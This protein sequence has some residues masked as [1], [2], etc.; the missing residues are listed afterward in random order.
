MFSLLVSLFTY[1]R[2]RKRLTVEFDNTCLIFNSMKNIY[3]N[4]NLFA[5]PAPFG[6]EIGISLVNPG[7]CNISIFDLMVINQRT[8]RRQSFLLKSLIPDVYKN[9]QLKIYLSEKERS[10]P[11]IPE[12][13]SALIRSGE[14]VRIDLV[15]LTETD[16]NN[17]DALLITFKSTDT[18]WINRSIYN[19]KS[20]KHIYHAYEK[21]YS[22]SDAEVITFEKD[23]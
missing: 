19:K 7:H 17:T 11:E 15:I 20:K 5:L 8:G 4:D 14:Y 1:W 6:V 9:C 21:T 23:R 18:S 12:R 16:T 22:L 3:L 13:P 2:Q 10:L